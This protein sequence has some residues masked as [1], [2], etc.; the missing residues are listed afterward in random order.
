MFLS[1][2][3][4][5]LITFNKYSHTQWDRDSKNYSIPCLLKKFTWETQI[6]IIMLMN[7]YILHR[8]WKYT[9][10]GNVWRCYN[11]GTCRKEVQVQVRFAFPFNMWNN[12]FFLNAFSLN[13]MG[14]IHFFNSVHKW[15]LNLS[16]LLLSS[17]F[18]AFK[19]TVATYLW[20]MYSSR[21]T[22]ASAK[23]TVWKNFTVFLETIVGKSY[24]GTWTF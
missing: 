4:K 17:N 13:E 23:N 10:K 12:Y 16:I 22:A 14:P 5:L 24:Y 6:L 7:I 20:L 8:K 2:L 15:I 21:H 18:G 9:N 11:Y 1:L 19:L 3:M